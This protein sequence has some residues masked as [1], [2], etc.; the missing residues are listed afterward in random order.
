MLLV[1]LA[2]EVHAVQLDGSVV[3]LEA[4][5]LELLELLDAQAD[6]VASSRL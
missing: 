4:E 5:L 3:F 1:L 6:Q 2:L